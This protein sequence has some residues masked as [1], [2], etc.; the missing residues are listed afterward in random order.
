M[1]SLP[2]ITSQLHASTPSLPMPDLGL[3]PKEQVSQ[4][5]VASYVHQERVKRQNM[6]QKFLD[7]CQSFEVQ[8][9]TCLIESDQTVKA[10]MELIPVLDIKR[11]IVGTSKSNL[12][13]WKKGSCKAVQFQ[14]NAPAHCEV[15]IICDGRQV[16][17][18]Y[19]QSVSSSPASDNPVSDKNT[20]GETRNKKTRGRAD[21]RCIPV[22]LL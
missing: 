17:A 10:V 21:C 15:K 22:K 20:D 9:D 6:L 4:A 13:K 14:Q 19:Q 18:P 16:T 1:S 12:R 11:L 3:L 7:L 2:S 8:Y 5:Q